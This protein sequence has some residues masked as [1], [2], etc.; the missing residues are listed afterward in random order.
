MMRTMTAR[1]R[2]VVLLAL[3]LATCTAPIAVAADPLSLQE[4]IDLA[5]RQNLEFLNDRQGLASDRAQ[6]RLAKSEFELNADARF[7]APNYRDTRDLI[8]TQTALTRFREENTIM[9]Y[10]GNLEL[11]QRVRHLGLFTI[12]SSGF[13]QDFSSN[14]RQDFL[15]LSGDIQF[16]YRHDILTTPQAEIDLKRAELGLATG[17]ASFERR[18]LFLEDRV[19]GAFY[20]LVQSVRQLEIQQQRLEQSQSSLDL[21]QRK[22]EIGLIAEVEALRLNVEKL[23]AEANVAQAET[24]IERRRDILRDLLG[25]EST[26]P[27]DVVT[28]VPYER[29]PIDEGRALELG[30][31]RRTDMLEAEILTQLRELSLKETRQRNGP[32][33]TLNATVGLRGRG[34]ELADVSSNF[35]RNLI[36]ARIDI[37]L[38]L[39]DSGRRRNQIRLAEINLE[40]SRLSNEIQEKDVTRQ[41]RDAVRTVKEAE[42]QIELRQAARQ[43]AERTFEV[44]QSRFELGLADSQDLL[45]AQTSLTAARLDALDAV[46]NY[47]R[48]LKNLNLATMADLTELA[49]PK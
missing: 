43:F 12:S 27:L 8:E 48:R 36:T 34:E 35:E 37:Q 41:I 26:D 3:A 32:T 5:A 22:F 9:T 17:R 15:D 29:V 11:T 21:A 40:R 28:E 7:T 25:L 38:P 10:S 6:L 16:R 13:R 31:T 23:G 44:E 33:A 24:D 39:L 19:T 2:N 45:V 14:R 4:C 18:E 42:R 20:D 30:L 49:G 46:L 47:Q 1:T